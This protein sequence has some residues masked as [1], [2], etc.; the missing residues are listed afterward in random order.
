[1]KLAVLNE[2]VTSYVENTGCL[3][4]VLS[5]TSQR[6]LLDEASGVGHLV[7]AGCC[8]LQGILLQ[9]LD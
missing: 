2:G 3:R 6:A 4:L 5:S 8:V 7:N 9:A 1:M